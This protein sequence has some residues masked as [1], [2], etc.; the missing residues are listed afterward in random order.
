MTT[1]LRVAVAL[2]LGL[3]VAGINSISG[4]GYVVLGEVSVAVGSD[5]D[6][7]RLQVTQ[8]A[9]GEERR[10]RDEAAALSL[11]L[12]TA[13]FRFGLFLIVLSAAQILAAGVLLLRRQVRAAGATFLTIV[14]LAGVAAEAF[15]ARLVPPFGVT[16]ILGVVFS[17]LLLVT[18]GIMF[19]G[20]RA[21][22]PTTP[23]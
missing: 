2:G 16:N 18:A 20:R 8:T 1:G 12:D 19:R 11:L 14:G 6:D 7:P 4:L 13:P 22:V 9:E 21:S 3:L 10:P 23:V 15:G 5:P 17:V